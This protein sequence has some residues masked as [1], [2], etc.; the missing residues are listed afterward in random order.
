VVVTSFTGYYRRQPALGVP[1]EPD[2]IRAAVQRWREHLNGKLASFRVRLDW[3]ETAEEEALRLPV[4]ADA[5][6]AV[7]LLAAYV[8]RTELDLPLDLPADLAGDAVWQAAEASEFAQ[9]RL[10]QVAVPDCWLPGDFDLTV[11]HAYPDGLEATFGSLGALQ[12]HLAELNRATF[13]AEPG[14]L[15]MTPAAG[16]RDLLALGEAGLAA[17]WRGARAAA[18]A[19]LPMLL[20]AVPEGD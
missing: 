11:K 20:D 2:A 6:R 7:R 9:V 17:L 5:L 12:V 4:A 15:G 3:A 8:D 13:Q 1:S 14:E 19:R 10:A 16:G 18:A